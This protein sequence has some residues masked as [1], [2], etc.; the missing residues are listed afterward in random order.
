MLHMQCAIPCPASYPR[1]EIQTESVTE[2]G[3]VH[4]WAVF[5]TGELSCLC[6]QRVP[7]NASLHANK[8]EA[9]PCASR[10]RLNW[11]VSKLDMKWEATA[12]VVWYPKVAVTFLAACSS[13]LPA[14]AAAGEE[15]LY[16]TVGVPLAV[17]SCMQLKCCTMHMMLT[18]VVL[19]IMMLNIVLL[20]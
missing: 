6:M 20:G 12:G 10:A 11:V 15:A 13:F 18:M 4:S 5:T 9:L 7:K 3:A 14:A 17:G 2:D 8:G 19:N 1:Q 16:T